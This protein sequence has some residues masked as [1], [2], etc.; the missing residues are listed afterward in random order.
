MK[1]L[2]T[3]TASVLGVL[4]LAAGL[5]LLWASSG[6]LGEDELAQTKRYSNAAEAPAGDTLTVT[7]YNIGYLS[8]MTNNDPVVRSDSLFRANM[9]EATALLRRA[10]PD[11]IGFQEIDF[12]AARSASVHQL[13]TLATRLGYATAAQAVN[14]DERYVPF[15]YGLP[16]VHFGRILSGQAVLSRHPIHGHKRVVLARPDQL[17]IRDAFYLD[18]LAQVTLL[19]LGGWVLPVINVHLEAF[20]EATREKQAQRVNRLY[21]RLHDVGMPTI[22][23]GDL[24]SLPPDVW[25]RLPLEHQRT[26]AEDATIEL[27]IADTNL[28]PTYAGTGDTPERPA[29]TFPADAPNRKLDYIFYQPSTLE[30]VDHKTQCGAPSPPSDHCAVTATFR[31]LQSAQEGPAPEEVP[32]LDRLLSD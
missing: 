20:D 27:L 16:A 11:V 31:L 19:D 25:S 15:P 21:R 14:W 2:L 3:F 29:P 28:R 1:R 24:N 9:D 22:L 32:S 5:F 7:T 26:L 30:L 17:F 23:M 6:R 8:G 10:D 13:D 18:R 4:T 12:G